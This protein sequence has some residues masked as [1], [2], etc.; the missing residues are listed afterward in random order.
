MR[1]ILGCSIVVL[2]AIGLL[3]VIGATRS[4]I[5]AASKPRSAPQSIAPTRSALESDK[6][7]VPTAKQPPASKDLIANTGTTADASPRP[8][9][10]YLFLLSAL[11]RGS[12]GR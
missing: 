3:A 9:D 4:D 1:T 2:V 7:A 11:H 6:G 12:T 8:L 10:A 5:R